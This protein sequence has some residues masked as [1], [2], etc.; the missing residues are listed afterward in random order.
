[1]RL[2][3]WWTKSSTE[4]TVALAGVALAAAMVTRRGGW[5]GPAVKQGA[6]TTSIYCSAVQ[7]VVQRRAG[8]QCQRLTVVV[9]LL[10]LRGLKWSKH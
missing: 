8:R 3:L 2:W 9:A 5:R 6:T 4:Q 1:M 7:C 10:L